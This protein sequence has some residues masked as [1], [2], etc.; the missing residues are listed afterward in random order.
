MMHVK[1]DMQNK[2]NSSININHI[3]TT[4]KSLLSLR[5]MVELIQGI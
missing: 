5:A 4:L 1:N 2:S 3:K